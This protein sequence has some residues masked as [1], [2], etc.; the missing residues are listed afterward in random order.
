[1]ASLKVL[2]YNVRGINDKIKRKRLIS[3]MHKINPDI[4]LLQETHLKSKT[5]HI[6]N[7]KRFSYQIHSQGSSKARG[8]AILIHRRLRFEELDT[9]KDTQGRFIVTKGNLNGRLVTIAS[10]Y[11]PNE[12]QVAFIEDFLSKLMLFSGG[13][14]I[15]AG[16][17]NYI[18]D[19][20]ADRTYSGSRPFSSQLH[21]YTKFKSLLDTFGLVD[22]W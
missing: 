14:L 1:M 20:K 21:M 22:C 5:T 19:L 3:Q 15:C 18:V 4:L 9:W 7:D 6:L 2:T 10:I 11:A 13:S 17:F 12:G 16:D 8:T